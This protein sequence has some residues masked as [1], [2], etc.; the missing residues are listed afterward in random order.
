MKKTKR[1]GLD[2]KDINKS[3]MKTKEEEEEE[4]PISFLKKRR[5]LRQEANKGEEEESPTLQ[6]FLSRTNKKKTHTIKHMR[7]NNKVE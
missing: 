2:S 4:K 7:E 6:H 1:R 5:S 3:G